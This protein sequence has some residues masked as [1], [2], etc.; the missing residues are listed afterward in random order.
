M[1]VVS[2]EKLQEKLSRPSAD[3]PD[4]LLL[5]AV[6]LGAKM[7]GEGGFAPPAAPMENRLDMLAE[8]LLSLQSN[9][10]RRIANEQAEEVQVT[11]AGEAE[12]VDGQGSVQGE[13]AE[14]AVRAYG[15]GASE[16]AQTDGGGSID[17]AR[18]GHAVCRCDLDF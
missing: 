10:H 18:C 6:E 1:L 12:R 7:K 17:C 16:S 15:S 14:G 2:L 9:I 11:Q 3:I 5:K 4:Q 8:R 13:S